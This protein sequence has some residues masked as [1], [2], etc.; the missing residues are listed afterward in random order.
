MNLTFPGEK[1]STQQLLIAQVHVVGA[2]LGTR[3]ARPTAPA[4]LQ[5]R[6]GAVARNPSVP[7]L[8]WDP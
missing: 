2:M 6:V 8:T 7:E 1:S 5:P 4:S 3:R